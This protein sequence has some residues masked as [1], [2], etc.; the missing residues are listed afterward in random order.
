MKTF[1]NVISLTKNSRGVY[2]IDTTM[3]CASGMNEGKNGCYNECYSAKSAKLYGYDFSKTIIRDFKHKKHQQEI[4]NEIS[5]ADMPFIRIGSSGD[6]SEAWEHTI[7][8]CRKI[9]SGLRQIQI[10]IFGEVKNDKQIVIITKHWFKIPDHLLSELSSL[11]I[12]IN[13]SISAID[14][15][16]VLQYRISEYEKFKHYCKSILRLVSFDFNEEN[17]KGVQYKL[18]QDEILM[19]Y[20]VLE[21]VFRS[22]KS[23]SLVKENIIHIHKTKFLGK[24]AL[25]SKRNKKTYFGKCSTC[26]EMCGVNM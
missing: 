20:S 12:C 18:I 1:S 10:D 24:N 7:N 4:I 14:K 13:T 15:L 5:K 9:Q 22:S 17:E 8:I 23:N 25:V 11:N 26:I 3:G 19:N 2:S 21:T 16:D 6:P